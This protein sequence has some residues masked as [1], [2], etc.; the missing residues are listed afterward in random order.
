[1]SCS[2]RSRKTST[3]AAARIFSTAPGP[4]W[5]NSSSPTLTVLTCGATAA[6]QPTATARSAVSRATAI[7]ARSAVTGGGLLEGDAA[8]NGGI[9]GRLVAGRV[10][11]LRHGEHRRSVGEPDDV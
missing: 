10:G 9:D 3:S 4:S 6:V 8:R 5:E 2:F 7:G 11:R 1:M